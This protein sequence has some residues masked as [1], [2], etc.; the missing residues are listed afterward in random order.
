MATIEV[1]RF[2]VLRPW[3]SGPNGPMGFMSYDK[4]NFHMRCMEFDI[5]SAY[6]KLE[7][8]PSATSRFVH[9]KS[10]QNNKYLERIHDP[11]I[12]PP[13]IANYWITATADKP[14]EDRTKESCT[15]FR[16]RQHQSQIIR[17]TVRIDHVQSNRTL[18]FYPA[19]LPHLLG[20]V[21]TL[22][23]DAFPPVGGFRDIFEFRFV[24]WSSMVI[25]PR[26]VAFKRSDN[27]EYL[28]HRMIGN[29]PDPYLQFG[30]LDPGAEGV[31]CEV[32]LTAT[33]LTRVKTVSVDRIWR[34]TPDRNF[35]LPNASEPGGNPMQSQFTVG[36]LFRAVKVNDHTIALISLSNNRFCKRI[37]L[38]SNLNNCL[39]A[40]ATSVTTEARLRVEEAVMTREF[41]NIRYEL[42]N[43]RVYDERPILVDQRASLN[44]TPRPST[45]TVQLAYSVTQTSSWSNSASL[46]LGAS[47][48][49]GFGIPKIFGGELG[50]STEVQDEVQ[51]G[52]ENSTTM[53]LEAATR[54]T[55][56]A[57]T[58]V[59][60]RLTATRGKCD[61]P[62]TFIQRDTLYDGT[63]RITRQTGMY[64]GANLYNFEFVT[65]PTPT[66]LSESEIDSLPPHPITINQIEQILQA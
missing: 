31:A 65:T 7:V 16:F 28:A 52:K 61:V 11:S 40:E 55:V 15:L 32:S 26:Y 9:I 38:P 21:L 34:R 35:I 59:N 12:H 63:V 51:W 20:L 37:T 24:D 41:S 1:P 27:E 66:T 30:T 6:A 10:C 64:T 17:N 2:I 46:T 33:G 60:V 48:T 42:E 47:L 36:T 23:F 19:N 49:V 25:L 50:F 44:T 4:E 43:G 58:R 54:V 13:S 62:F 14:E 3:E 53:A 22:N 5:T 29:L 56:P 18:T 39:A 45:L 8:V 57:N